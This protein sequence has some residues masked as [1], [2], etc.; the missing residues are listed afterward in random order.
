MKASYYIIYRNIYQKCGWRINSLDS[1]LSEYL[2][3]A[4]FPRIVMKILA[5]N[6]FRGLLYTNSFVCFF[7][8]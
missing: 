3:F 2:I 5:G 1:Y 8:Q 7:N 6:P 4:V